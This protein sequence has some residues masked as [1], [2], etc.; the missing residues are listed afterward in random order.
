M[1]FIEIRDLNKS[2]F[3]PAGENEVLRNVD[4]DVNKGEFI[5]LF[6]PSGSGKTTFLNMVTGIDSPTSGDILVG[7]M[8]INQT[9]QRK[10]TKWRGK[11]IGIVFQFFQLLPT[12]TVLE[13]VVAPM[14]FCNVWEASER[15]ER[16]MELLDRFGIADQ[17]H[18]T[19]D[20]LSGGQQQR[21][22]IARALSNDPPLIVGDEP[23]GNLDRMS[24]TNVFNIF[25]ELAEAGRTVIVVTHDRELVQTKGLKLL[26]IRDGEVGET[27][28]EAATK[29]RT[30]ELAALRMQAHDN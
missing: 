4:L 16:A 17:A 9:R 20:M 26:E 25:R 5:A 11:N 10:L 24:A 15:K 27:S 18:K 14:D 6:G 3:T 28:L 8:T 29:R 7:D 12:L 30:E 19:P 22:A 23:T 2:Y 13:N 21:V 1:A